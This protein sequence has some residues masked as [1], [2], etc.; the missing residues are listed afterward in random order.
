MTKTGIPRTTAIDLVL[1][2]NGMIAV[3][4][5]AG[6]AR[7]VEREQH[8]QVRFEATVVVAL[9]APFPL[10]GKVRRSRVVTPRHA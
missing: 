4:V 6:V 9:I 3:V 10:S 7:L 2:R 1:P 8:L 5:A